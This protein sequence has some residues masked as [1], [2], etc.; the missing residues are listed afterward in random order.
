[1]NISINIA[2]RLPP[3]I[4]LSLVK[5]WTNT[6]V[7]DR[8]TAQNTSPCRLGCIGEKNIDSLDH[9]ISCEKL[10]SPVRKT[11]RAITGID[12]PINTLHNLAIPIGT[13]LQI[14]PT[15]L[16]CVF[17]AHIVLDTYQMIAGRQRKGIIKNPPPVTEIIKEAFRKLSEIT[18]WIHHVKKLQRQMESATAS[19]RSD[20]KSNLGCVTN[21]T[22]ASNMRRG[23]KR[24]NPRD[25]NS[26]RS[27]VQKRSRN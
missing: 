14:S 18:P 20:A 12:L 13:D 5:T 10:H 1:M 26:T 15:N 2:K 7:T 8:R 21:N 22:D 6:W 3:S 24:K 11:I 25:D 23:K 19:N 27:H 9:Y 16:A 4:I 17:K